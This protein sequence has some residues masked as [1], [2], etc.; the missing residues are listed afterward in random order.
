MSRLITPTIEKDHEQIGGVAKSLQ[1]QSVPVG[2]ARACASL[3]KSNF[4]RSLRLYIVGLAIVGR[5]H[6]GERVQVA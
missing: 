3:L 5:T 4:S 1:T 6:P 2:R